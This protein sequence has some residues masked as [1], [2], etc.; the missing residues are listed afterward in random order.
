MGHA[1]SPRI[2]ELSVCFIIEI[3]MRE[4]YE[5]HD[6]IRLSATT[7]WFGRLARRRLTLLL[8]LNT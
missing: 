2:C 3:A 8:Y 1:K 6:L 5:L 4:A 7:I